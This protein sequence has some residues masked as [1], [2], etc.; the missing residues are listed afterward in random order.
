MDRAIDNFREAAEIS[1]PEAVRS[2][3]QTPARELGLYG[4]YGVIREGARADLVLFD[5]KIS[6]RAT[7]IR[8]KTIFRDEI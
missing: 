6:V 5:E 1:L 2:A 3:T 7:I 8:G 4:E